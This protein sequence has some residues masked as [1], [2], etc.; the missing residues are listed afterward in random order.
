MNRLI[1]TLAAAATAIVTAIFVLNTTFGAQASP[2]SSAPAAPTVQ[3]TYV[4]PLS[5]GMSRP[6]INLPDF[7]ART[8]YQDYHGLVAADDIKYPP[9]DACYG[10]ITCCNSAWVQG[11]DAGFFEDVCTFYGGEVVLNP[12]SDGSINYEC[13]V[14]HVRS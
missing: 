8:D 7:Q 10:M 13:Q 4:A 1:R 11:C 9:I 12:F 3:P 5:G 6:V 14:F 2:T